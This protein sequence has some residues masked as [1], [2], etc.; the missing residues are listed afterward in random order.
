MQKLL[1]TE[2]K[3][4]VILETNEFDEPL[5]REF[6]RLRYNHFVLKLKSEPINEAGLEKDLY[7]DFA[8]YIVCICQKAKRI[9]GGCRI[10][11]ADKTMLPISRTIS[12][13]QSN[14]IE[15]SRLIAEDP[16]VKCKLYTLI[17]SYAAKKGI[18][19]GYALVRRGITRIIKRDK[20][21]VFSIVGEEVNYNGL[22]LVP[23]LTSVEKIQMLAPEGIQVY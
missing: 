20:A 18:V 5:R 9:I 8:D 2:G 16:M 7:D 6:Q 3:I 1:E 14:S 15:I 12:S 22:R 17:Y 23:L 19:Y 21:D 11:R 4:Y 10:I 13:I